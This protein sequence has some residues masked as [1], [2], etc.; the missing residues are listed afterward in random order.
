MDNVNMTVMKLT[1]IEKLAVQSILF[2]EKEIQEKYATPLVLD[3]MQLT[4]EL[5]QARSLSIGAIGK[6]HII[7]TDKWEIIELPDQTPKEEEPLDIND[8]I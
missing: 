4:M 6:T 5:E 2:R 1:T 7:D 3:K 8:K